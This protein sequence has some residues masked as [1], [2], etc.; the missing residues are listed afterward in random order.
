MAV[1]RLREKG[2]VI[3][4]SVP[5]STRLDSEARGLPVLLRAAPHYYNTHQEIDR[6]AEALEQ[7][8]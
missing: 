5:S 4:A 2:I 1:L 7:L 8:T 3:G 6:A